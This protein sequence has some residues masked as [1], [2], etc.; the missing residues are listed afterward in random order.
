MNEAPA[1]PTEPTP[2]DTAVVLTR[3]LTLLEQQAQRGR[4]EEFACAILLAVT[5]MASAWCAYQSVLWSGVQTFRLA[6]ANGAARQASE[7]SVEA[8]Q[9]RAFDATMFISYAAAHTAGDDKV[10][11]FLRARFR[12]EMRVAMEA[13][14]ATEPFTNPKAPLAPFHMKE[15]VQLEARQAR[16]QNEEAARM[17]EAAQHANQFSDRY[18]LLTVL[19]A[20][21]LFFGGI[22]GT[23][24]SVPL[25]RLFLA[26]ALIVFLTTSAVLATM[27]LC[28][29]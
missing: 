19:F 11:A 25:H 9:L 24:R 1:V 28:Y 23:M 10:A 21:V 16:E 6:A 27:P 13:W 22:A 5:T 26:I 7:K 17:H 29:E 3:I 15:Y 20:T 8:L 18:V 4:W 12:P 2:P 14:L